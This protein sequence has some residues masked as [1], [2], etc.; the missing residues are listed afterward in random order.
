MNSRRGGIHENNHTLF[1]DR[2]RHF[3]IGIRDHTTRHRNG[4]TTSRSRFVFNGENS[5]QGKSAPK[6]NLFLVSLKTASRS[7]LRRQRGGKQTVLGSLPQRRLRQFNMRFALR[8]LDSRRHQTVLGRLPPRRL[9][10][11]HLCFSVRN[12]ES[13]GDH[14]VLGNLHQRRLRQLHVLK[15][16]WC[17]LRHT[18]MSENSQSSARK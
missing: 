3:G 2:L 15:P 17:K 10:Q 8:N 12:F 13:R 5:S 18:I 14:G 7:A 4:Q 1:I 9:W 16:L 11:L 6:S